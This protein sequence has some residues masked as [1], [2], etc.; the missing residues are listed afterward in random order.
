MYIISRNGNCKLHSH[1]SLLVFVDSFVMSI[2]NLFPTPF[3][4]IISLA[5]K[6]TYTRILI[7]KQQ[8]SMI[9]GPT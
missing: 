3:L 6:P 7:L 4:Y 5:I 8:P 9:N 1:G 2:I